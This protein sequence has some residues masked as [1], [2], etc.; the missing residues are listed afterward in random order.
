MVLQ[1]KKS[2]IATRCSLLLD[3][4]KKTF[5]LTTGELKAY[6]GATSRGSSPSPLV[7]GSEDRY[8]RMPDCELQEMILF[9]ERSLQ[10]TKM[11]N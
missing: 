5:E 3:L 10:I 9:T 1:C 11:E 8:V 4:R 2:E 7:E 6:S